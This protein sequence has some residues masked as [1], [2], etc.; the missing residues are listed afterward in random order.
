[1]AAATANGRDARITEEMAA[2]L[3][4]GADEVG[5]LTAK[6]VHGYF[7]ARLAES[8]ASQLKV[9]VIQ[10]GASVRVSAALAAA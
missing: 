5:T 2:M 8:L 3:A 9:A 1:M 7:T 10:A 4:A 6:T